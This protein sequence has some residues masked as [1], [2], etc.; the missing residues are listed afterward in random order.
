MPFQVNVTDKNGKEIASGTLTNPANF[1]TALY[2]ATEKLIGLYY[3]NTQDYLNDIA[4]YGD[5]LRTGKFDILG[6]VLNTQIKQAGGMS[7]IK[8]NGLPLMLPK[9]GGK[10]HIMITAI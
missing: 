8:K 1:L 10:V 4:G 5:T 2:D 7:S 6:Q 3:R 9:A